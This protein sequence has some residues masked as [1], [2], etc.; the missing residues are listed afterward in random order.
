MK[1]TASKEERL[2]VGE[3]AVDVYVDTPY[4]GF[5]QR[6]KMVAK[7]GMEEAFVKFPTQPFPLASVKGPDEIMD[8]KIPPFE[9]MG[10]EEMRNPP[11]VAKSL[12][13]HEAKIGRP[14]TMPAGTALP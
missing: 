11:P 13:L 12:S 10:E 9:L 8:S 14:N 2:A 5:M 1:Q 3:G 7:T 6:E 4:A